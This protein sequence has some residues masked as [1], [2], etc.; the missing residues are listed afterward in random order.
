[1]SDY[2]KIL[3]VEK[4]ASQDDIKK[5]YRKLAMKYHP[6][7]NPD[8]EEAENKFKEIAE[9]YETL[10]DEA[11]KQFYDRYGSAGPRRQQQQQQYSGSDFF[12]STWSNSARQNRNMYGEDLNMRINISLED[13]ISKDSTKIRFYNNNICSTCSGKAMKD[14]ASKI[15]CSHCNG[16]GFNVQQRRTRNGGVM[17]SHAHCQE[18]SGSGTSIKEEDKCP[19]CDGKG[20]FEEMD[21]IEIP[22]SDGIATGITMQMQ[23]RGKYIDP[24]GRRGNLNISFN[25]S[26]HEIFEVNGYNIFMN[27]PITYSEAVLGTTINI[28]TIYESREIKVESGTLDGDSITVK[29]AG[30]P[31]RHGDKADMI[32]VFS[33]HI[34]QDITEEYREAVE[35]LKSVESNNNLKDLYKEK[36]IIGK[37]RK[38]KA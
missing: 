27:Q 25:I 7:K 18:C 30:L 17:Q 9:A 32:V 5:S 21:S 16:N 35:N 8:N 36:R 1:M 31:D 6:D 20:L 19:D 13:L 38:A 15:K 22:L 11:K 37:Y 24:K 12:R 29:E 2:Y 26:D 28:P 10:S 23:G 33:I 34:P 4:S 14:G 3:G